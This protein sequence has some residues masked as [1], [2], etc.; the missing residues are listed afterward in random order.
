MKRLMRI[1]VGM[2]FLAQVIK[3]GFKAE[4]IKGMPPHASFVRAYY[5][6]EREICC[7]IFSHQT[8]D[9]VKEGG[10]IP[11][12]MCEYRDVDY[13]QNIKA[14]AK[15]PEAKP[16][17]EDGKNGSVG[18]VAEIAKGNLTEKPKDVGKASDDTSSIPRK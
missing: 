10:L 8:F 15:K 5:E 11:E 4:C 13:D 12:M 17:F 16:V 1:A 7:L 14:K 9:L 18:H 2:H 3:K 6:E